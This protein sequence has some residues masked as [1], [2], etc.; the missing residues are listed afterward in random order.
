MRNASANYDFIDRGR[1][2]GRDELASLA[3]DTQGVPSP[4]TVLFGPKAPP[5]LEYKWYVWRVEAEKTET[6]S[7]IQDRKLELCRVEA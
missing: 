5:I 1:V 6:A 4:P 3:L 7:V 2:K